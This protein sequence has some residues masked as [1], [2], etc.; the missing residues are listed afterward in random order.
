MHSENSIWRAQQFFGV[1]V[2]DFRPL[3]GGYSAHK[4]I[5]LGFFFAFFNWNSEVL[6]Q[7]REVFIFFYFEVKTINNYDTIRPT[8]AFFSFCVYVQA[9]NRMME[10][11]DVELDFAFHSPRVLWALWAL[12]THW[13][14]T[15]R[16]IA[17]TDKRQPTSFWLIVVLFLWNAWVPVMETMNSYLRYPA[18]PLHHGA[19]PGQT[20]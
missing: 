10:S 11:K 12:M 6:S 7:N 2:L 17:W 19:V 20:L 9:N 15:S 8:M 3:H 13:F 18:F 1:V 16:F 5:T 14:W 4:T